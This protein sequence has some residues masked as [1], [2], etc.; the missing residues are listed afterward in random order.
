MQTDTPGAPQVSLVALFPTGHMWAYS[1][2][3]V[4]PL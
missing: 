2:L 1:Q 3:S 4:T